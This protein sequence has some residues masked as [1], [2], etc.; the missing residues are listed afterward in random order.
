MNKREKI[1]TL[2]ENEYL[3]VGT[4]FNGYAENPPRSAHSDAGIY[5]DDSAQINRIHA[6]AN[7]FLGQSVLEPHAAVKLFRAKINHAGLDF[8][9]NNR[10]ELK[11]GPNRFQLN[12][13]GEIF[14]ATPTTNLMDGFDRGFDMV[15]LSLS[16]NIQKAPN[17]K[18]YFNDVMIT[19]DGI[20]DEIETKSPSPEVK[21]SFDESGTMLLESDKPH[22][23]I[24][25]MAMRNP[26]IKTRVLNPLFQS[27]LSKKLNKQSRDQRFGFAARSIVR[28]L[29]GA[30]RV[31]RNTLGPNVLSGIERELRRRAKKVRPLI[32]S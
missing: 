17:G 7:S 22:V 30:G 14:G 1:K 25:N 21:E 32:D 5:R 9:F 3:D 28:R 12:R 13:F 4:V 27:M 10:T 8:E 15:P 20:T 29:H 16:F 11:L 31:D 6:F 26:E 19:R 18:F 24:V 2:L 23:S